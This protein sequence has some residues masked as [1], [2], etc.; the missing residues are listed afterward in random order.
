VNIDDFYPTKYAKASDVRSTKTFE[1]L[2]I[3]TEEFEKGPKPVLFFKGANKGVVLNKTN[4]Q[5]LKD[6][7]GSDTDNW[8]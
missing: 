1:L 5:R 4:S 2:D 6:E 8:I 7:F 3:A